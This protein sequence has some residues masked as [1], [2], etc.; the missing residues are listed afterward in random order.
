MGLVEYKGENFSYID[1][2]E[3]EH[4]PVAKEVRKMKRLCLVDCWF[5]SAKATENVI[6]SGHYGTFVI[7][8]AHACSTKKW[9]DATMK[10]VLGGS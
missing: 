6:K 5:G 2:V 1:S 10:D 4:A 7:K 8:T 3:D 9:L